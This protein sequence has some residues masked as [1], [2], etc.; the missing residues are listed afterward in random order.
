MKASKS[1]ARRRH[2]RVS[3]S[4]PA[5]VTSEGHTVAASMKDVSVGGLFLFTDIPFQAGSEIEV[6]LMLPRELGLPISEMVC[7]RGTVVRVEVAAGRCGIAAKIDR[8]ADV[9]QV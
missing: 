5:T 6:V 2:E 4:A 3:V 1:D 8:I 7:C 9:P